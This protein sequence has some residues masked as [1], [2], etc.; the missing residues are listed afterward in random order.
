MAAPQCWMHWRTSRLLA[1]EVTPAALEVS[2]SGR[3]AYVWLF[4]SDAVPASAA[5]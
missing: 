2:Q 3:G 5:R 4:F 1:F